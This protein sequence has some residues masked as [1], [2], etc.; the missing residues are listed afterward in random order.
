[1][2]E[3]DALAEYLRQFGRFDEKLQPNDKQAVIDSIAKDMNKEND[4]SKDSPDSFWGWSDGEKAKVTNGAIDQAKESERD[5]SP[6][7]AEEIEE[8]MWEGMET[9]N[10]ERTAYR[11]WKPERTVEAGDRPLEFPTDFRLDCLLPWERGTSTLDDAVQVIE[12]THHEIRHGD[13]ITTPE[14][15][16]YVVGPPSTKLEQLQDFPDIHWEN[17]QSEPVKVPSLA[18]DQA[19]E[20]PDPAKDIRAEY[21]A[22][23]G[24]GEEKLTR[25]EEENIIV[26][27]FVKQFNEREVPQ[28]RAA[29]MALDESK[30]SPEQPKEF[31]EA[32]QQS[33]IKD[34]GHV[35]DSHERREPSYVARLES[36]VESKLW[37]GKGHADE[38]MILSGGQ[39]ANSW[40]DSLRPERTP[41][42]FSA[43]IREM[44]LESAIERQKAQ[45]AAKNK[46]AE[47]EQERGGEGMEP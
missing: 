4:Q 15:I 23:L 17:Y 20:S 14:G 44:G 36:E 27:E 47:K 45:E 2:A 25:A 12:G 37:Q 11:L 9:E 32:E 16:G 46:T 33:D 41:Q 40:A 8:G 26:D 1:M 39:T 21:M 6:M 34:F 13:I 35:I 22:I 42:D 28:A 7:T 19:K 18:R 24:H 10:P 43:A 38:K 29:K 31:T 5:R 30:Q 3:R